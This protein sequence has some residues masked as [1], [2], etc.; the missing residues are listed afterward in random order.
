MAGVVNLI[1]NLSQGKSQKTVVQAFKDG[2]LKTGDY[3]NYQNPVG[4]QYTSPAEKNGVADQNFTVD[5]TTQWRVLGLS[6]DGKNLLLTTADPIKR[7]EVANSNIGNNITDS[8]I[9]EMKE[10]YYYY[11]GGAKGAFYGADNKEGEGELDRICSIYR[12]DLAEEARSITINDINSLLNLIVKYDNPNAGVY[13]KEDINYSENFDAGSILEF[14]ES[15]VYNENDETPEKALGKG[16]VPV[17]KIETG[18]SYYYFTNEMNYTIGISKE[19]DDLLFDGTESFNKNYW[20]ASIG[21]ETDYDYVDFGLGSVV[22]GKVQNGYDSFLF[23]SNG[24]DSQRQ[25]GVRPVISLKS[26]ITVNQLKVISGSKGE[27]WGESS[28]GPE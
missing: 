17:G 9:E 24:H 26:E 14:M 8:D 7:G 12:N 22:D 3:V 6:E 2:E 28:G 5:T 11:L 18:N 1:D 21:I 16:T 19:I 27:D 20:L 23:R 25:Y 13:K 4:S 15:H 10:N